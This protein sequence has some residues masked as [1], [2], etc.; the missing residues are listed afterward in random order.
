[1]RA[2]RRDHAV[3]ADSFSGWLFR[4]AATREIQMADFANPAMLAVE[5]GAELWQAVDGTQGQSC[6]SCHGNVEESM[7]AVRARMPHVNAKGELWS[8]EDHINCCRT[9]RMG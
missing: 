6:Q 9:E 8:M 3:L 1:M 2:N 5:N 4:D 7:R